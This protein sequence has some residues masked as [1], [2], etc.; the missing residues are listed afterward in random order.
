MLYV[1]EQKEAWLILSAFMLFGLSFTRTE[2]PIWVLTI[3]ALFLLNAH[4]RQ[5]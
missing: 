3:T 4:I 5:K 2:T 1:L